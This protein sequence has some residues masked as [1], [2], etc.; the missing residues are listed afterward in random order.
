MS[1]KTVILT[2]NLKYKE[3]PT[4]ITIG[5]WNEQQLKTFIDKVTGKVNDECLCSFDV[6]NENHILSECGSTLFYE[7]NFDNLNTNAEELVIS[8]I[9]SLPVKEIYPWHGKCGAKSGNQCLE[10]IQTGKCTSSVIKALVGRA[11]F[12]KEY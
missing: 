12:P 8:I 10:N 7:N 11:L 4:K 1:D 2:H 9:P 6:Y 5:K 3:Y